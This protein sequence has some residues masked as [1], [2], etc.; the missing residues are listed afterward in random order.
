MPNK[1]LDVLHI[2]AECSPFIKIGGLGDVL[3]SLPN[4][5][6]TTG[7]K[8][9]VLLPKYGV[10][11]NKKFGLKKVADNIMV[12]I[13][14][15]PKKVALYYTRLPK[16]KVD[17]YFLDHQIF[18][19]KNVYGKA[20]GVSSIERFTF[21]DKAAV[22]AIRQYLPRPA[23]IQA[24]DWHAGLIPTFIDQASQHYAGF[25]QI[26]TLFTIHNLAQQGQTARDLLDYINILPD[27]EPA[28]M[29]DYYDDDYLNLMKIAILSADLI[30]AVSPNYAKEILTK[31][32]GAGLETYLQ[33]RRHDLSGIL[34]GID[35]N[36]F[37][38]RSD[39]DIKY[40]FKNSNWLKGKALNKKQL[41]LTLGLPET[42]GPLYGLISRLTDQK[43]LDI[44]LSALKKFLIKNVQVVILGTGSLTY[45][46]QLKNLAKQ[47]P[48]KLAV[49]LEFNLTLAKQ[50]YAGSDLF[51]MPSAYEP[52]GLGQMIA[53]RY[54]S[55]PLVRETG[56]LKDTVQNGRTGFTF[57]NYSANTLAKT[58]NNSLEFYHRKKSW[59]TLVTNCLQENFSWDK[60]AQAYIK[61]YKQLQ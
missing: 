55:V 46:Q 37:N 31:K 53:M 19:G 59:Y 39:K 52:C 48:N 33:R 8:T 30:N 3:G 7:L 23:V 26:K 35:N 21:F 10:I 14:D 28:L 2:A 36:E 54:G 56:G 22:E 6:A 27:Q 32:Y 40:K 38:P 41:L 20:N 29:E 13:G 24:H 43:G 1:K 11:N 15:H 9:A 44:L 5:L 4:S 51:M 12:N 42:K 16:S 34:N 45:H 49:Q 50:I 47:F 18:S 61:L 17:Y 58:L 57:R 25:H 60:S